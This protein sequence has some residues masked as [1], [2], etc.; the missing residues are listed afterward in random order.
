MVFVGA[1]LPAGC[2][3]EGDSSSATATTSASTAAA[4][5]APTPPPRSSPPT[6]QPPGVRVQTLEPNLAVFRGPRTTKDRMPSALLAKVN[7]ALPLEYR[8][9]RFARM[10]E[11]KP[12]YLVPSPQMTCLI[13][14]NESVGSCWGTR[15]V[16]GG[17]ATN[18]VLCA[19]ALSEHE[20]VTF[21]IAHDG[22]EEATT[23]R[24]NG[25]DV[26]VPVL[27]NVYIAFSSS[28]PPL[29]ARLALE[30]EGKRAVQRSG[31]PRSAI[32]EGCDVSPQKSGR[33]P[34]DAQ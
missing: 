6:G 3:G 34:R 26:T 24:T 4:K 27:G 7:P 33:R 9:S 19:P 30:G 29:P 14:D 31:I 21:G 32:N 13:T 8:R 15:A 23:I 1:V 20:I 2:G 17:F 11:G 10:F 5:P 28:E 18:T 16:R 22:F 12:V 25:P